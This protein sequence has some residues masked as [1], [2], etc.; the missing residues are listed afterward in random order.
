MDP[1]STEAPKAHAAVIRRGRYGRAVVAIAVVRERRNG[2]ERLNKEIR[3]RERAIRIS[4]NEESLSRLIGALLME[5]ND[6][7]QSEKVYLNLTQVLLRLVTKAVI[8]L[9]LDLLK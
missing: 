2:I 7:W 1:F 6:G 9:W 4:P 3:R 8:E 5:I